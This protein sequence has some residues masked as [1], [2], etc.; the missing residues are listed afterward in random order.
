MNLWRVKLGVLALYISFWI[1]AKKNT[2]QLKWAYWLTMS[3]LISKNKSPKSFHTL[4]QT[5]SKWGK[6]HQ[7]CYQAKGV[8]GISTQALKWIWYN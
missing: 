8:L 7:Q 1:C 4:E 3:N 2:L 5:K 6:M